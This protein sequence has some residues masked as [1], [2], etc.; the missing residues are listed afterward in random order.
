MLLEVARNVLHTAPLDSTGTLTIGVT[1]KELVV[2]GEF[3]AG[4]AS[5]LASMFH[6]RKVLKIIWTKE[7][8][9]EDVWSFARLMSTPKLQGSE[10]REK[11]RFEI[12]TIDVEPLK[13]D[14]IHS[15]ITEAV[16][17]S[18]NN[19]EQRRRHAW[20]ILMSH[21]APTEQLASALI[22]EEFWETAKA[23]WM[24]LGYSD[25]EGFTELLLK[26]GE[27]LEDAL[28][29]L[30]EEQRESILNYLA[31]MGKCL[32]VKDLV[33]IVGQGSQES[34]RLGLGKTSLL[35]E[36]DGERFIDLLA[37]LASLGDQGTRRFVEVYRRFAP[38]TK[39]DDLLSL[40]KSRL[41]PGK[42]SGFAMEVWKTVEELIL[43]LTE[44]PFMDT[45]YFESLEFLVDHSDSMRPNEDNLIQ[46]EGPDEYLDQLVLAL[47]LEEEGDYR[48]KLLHRIEARIEQIGVLRVLRFVNLVDR[49]IPGL[50]DSVPS[51]VIKLF[52]KGLSTL[53][54]TLIVEQQALLTFA[55]N[56]EKRLLDVALKALAEEKQ[57]STR[58]F[59]VNLLSCFSSAATPTF[60]LKSR[61]SPWYVARNLAIVLGKQGFPQ[62]LPP[63]RA[64]LKHPNIKVRK[65]AQKSM[66]RVQTSLLYPSGEQE[67]E[68]LIELNLQDTEE[69]ENN[70]GAGCP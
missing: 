63:L 37:G 46:L 62:V 24:N 56:H 41:S 31:Q 29:L 43:N 19:P 70:Y 3:V 35:K 65:E 44:N 30:P 17:D 25:S 13:L 40:V 28:A 14:Q 10:L 5:N 20:L 2:S 57:I 36:I 18:E 6:A 64:L 11:L 32:S 21:E 51:L 66:K 15:E 39:T 52:Q 55:V 8:T 27:R 59:L 58:H 7:V 61:T 50:L 23:E 34:G 53:L 22:S 26:L 33:Q 48:K 9:L 69:M 67:G 68:T 38:V 12:S 1:S 4:K 54:K 45:E 47:A 60:V 49:T 16:Q 42:N